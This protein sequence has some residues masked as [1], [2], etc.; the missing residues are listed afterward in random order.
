MVLRRLRGPLP[1][2]RWSLGRY[3]I[4]INLGAI[5]FLLI[6]W[7]FI[8]FPISTGQALTPE[9]MNW[10]CVMFGG[11]MIFA[12]GYYFVV[13]HKRYTPP[14]TLVKRDE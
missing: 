10:N 6:V 11:S 12:I 7:V 4:L 2:H 13:G 14:V 1:P 8:F 9:T 5:S 3:G